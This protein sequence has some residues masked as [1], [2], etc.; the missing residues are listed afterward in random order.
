MA[1]SFDRALWL[2]END[3][4]CGVVLDLGLL[5]WDSH[6]N[7]ESKQRE[8]N[9]YFARFFDEYLTKLH[10]RSNGFGVL[11]QRTVTVVGSELG[12]FPHQNDMFGKDHFPQTSFLLAGPGIRA[13]HT[14]GRTGRRMEGLPIAY[15][16]G[17]AVQAGRVPLLDDLGSTLLHL[18]ELVPERYG[19]SGRVC[20]FLLDP[21]S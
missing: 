2:I 6:I 18:A 20:D 16:D 3:L 9:W 17:N 10:S 11:A 15:T 5:G 7:N 4:C 12:R 13:G 8:M 19:Y 21:T 1:E 14:F